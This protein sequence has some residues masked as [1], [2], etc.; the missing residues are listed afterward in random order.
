MRR[1]T[2]SVVTLVV[3]ACCAAPASAFDAYHR[4]FLAAC[5]GVVVPIGDFADDDLANPQAGGAKT[6]FDLGLRLEYGVTETFLVG[7]RFGYDRFDVKREMLD[8]IAPDLEAHWTLTEIFG[9][10]GKFLA[11]PGAATRPYARAGAFLGKPELTFDS[12]DEIW[13]GEYDV[14]LGLEAAIGVTHM[15]SRNVGF[16][17]EA[18][19][20]HLFT[21]D[22]DSG[23]DAE[24][25]ARIAGPS[26]VRDPGGNVSLIDLAAFV[27]YSF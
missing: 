18:R 13:S 12:G 20:A 6:G 21:S 16:G 4:F 14:S 25:L 8:A 7:G 26:G 17:F 24:T 19:F 23:D 3:I 11:M 2:L 15:F 10:Y 5:G 27:D 1:L 22:S 9:L